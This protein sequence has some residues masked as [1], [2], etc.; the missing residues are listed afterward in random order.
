[1]Q[2]TLLEQLALFTGQLQ[3]LNHGVQRLAPVFG[4]L[5]RHGQAEARAIVGN[6]LAGPIE[7]QAPIGR[8]GLHMN[9]VVFRERGVMLVLHHLQIIQ[10]RNQH[11]DQQHH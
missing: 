1:M 5:T 7:D 3:H 10:A 8:N 2:Y 4:A 11:A 9:A 6:D